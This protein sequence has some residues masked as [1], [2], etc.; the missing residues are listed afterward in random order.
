MASLVIKSSEWKISSRN[1]EFRVRSYRDQCFYQSDA[2][3]LKW[4]QM[5]V[6]TAIQHK[7]DVF[8]VMLNERF[9][10]FGNVSMGADFDAND[11]SAV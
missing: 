9:C 3:S 6:P 8:D 2:L 7:Q 1:Y 11:K 5:S 10:E 4:Q